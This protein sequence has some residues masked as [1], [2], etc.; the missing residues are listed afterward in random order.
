[1]D[2]HQLLLDWDKR[3]RDLKV[4]ETHCRAVLTQEADVRLVV[5]LARNDQERAATTYARKTKSELALAAGAKSPNTGLA[6]LK[7][8]A[9]RGIL[10]W[11]VAPQRDGHDILID[12]LALWDLEPDDRPT[13]LRAKLQAE[14][15]QTAV[16]PGQAP[17]RVL[18]EQEQETRVRDVDV[19][20]RVR[21]RGARLVRPWHRRDGLSG[22]D[23][24]A[25]VR[26]RDREVLTRLYYAGI[27]A[28]WWTDRAVYRQR[29]V[30][31]CYQAVRDSTINP[32]ALLHTLVKRHLSDKPREERAGGDGL[33]DEADDWATATRRAWRAET[34]SDVT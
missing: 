33:S 8:L 5:S 9:S 34:T 1:M 30:A 18:G 26:N 32:M 27:E 14:A 16:R 13:A 17:P 20:G 6:A 24:A 11:E 7:R 31:C 2:A 19:S 4:L 21:G 25:A 15:G 29:F 3:D 22:D 12:W 28:S 23:L 10:A